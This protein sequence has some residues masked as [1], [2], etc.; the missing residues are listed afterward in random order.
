MTAWAG[1]GT[2]TI[3]AAEILGA[4]R[5]VMK[6]AQGRRVVRDIERAFAM[7][8]R[9]VQRDLGPTRAGGGRSARAWVHMTR[10]RLPSPEHQPPT[11][12]DIKSLL[13]LADGYISLTTYPLGQTS[14][15]DAIMDMLY[16]LH[17]ATPDE[18]DND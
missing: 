3:C 5:S 18:D 11:I 15:S 2:H 14:A 9:Q 12:A 8:A 4:G 13:A 17:E 7:V 10:L 1:R 16:I 6:M